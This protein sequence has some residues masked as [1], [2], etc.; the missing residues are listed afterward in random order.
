MVQLILKLIMLSALPLLAETTVEYP[1]KNL[2]TEQKQRLI[3]ESHPNKAHVYAR[4]FNAH[5]N[6]DGAINVN[7]E[8]NY[9]EISDQ[10]IGRMIASCKAPIRF[11]M[12][13]T[14]HFFS[15]EHINP[16]KKAFLVTLNF[17]DSKLFGFCK[18]GLFA[19][20]EIQVCEHPYLALLAQNLKE[21]A[22]EKLDANAY[23]FIFCN[24]PRLCTLDTQ[25]VV[26][27]KILYGNNFAKASIAEID[28]VLKLNSPAPCNNILAIAAS[29]VC[30]RRI[31]TKSMIEE[32][33][34][35]ILSGFEHAKKVS[36]SHKRH[37]LIIHTGGLG[38]GAFGHSKV[39]SIFL[40][41]LV[42]Q[43]VSRTCTSPHK[44][45]IRFFGVNKTTFS[46]ALKMFRDFKSS[47][48][49]ENITK[50]DAALGLISTIFNANAVFPH[51]G[52]GD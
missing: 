36:D 37:H 43:I 14:K 12:S 18:D 19:Q 21:T 35:R 45:S 26:H 40:Q 24:V 10:K 50:K 17:A 49:K 15:Y 22:P 4:C 7:S 44:F 28:H 6:L 47:V 46:K 52:T 16:I 34:G 1:L 51:N 9:S 25:K 8:E 33:L 30:G 29:N 11:N 48:K 23:S 38:C 42:A 39:A 20:D 3:A 27:D 32:F 13:S 5:E 31:Y 41:L 2:E